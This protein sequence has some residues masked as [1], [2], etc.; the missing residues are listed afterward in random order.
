MHTPL[1]AEE[2][3]AERS[4]SELSVYS[5]LNRGARSIFVCRYCETD[6]S[7]G[8]LIPVDTKGRNMRGAD[9]SEYKEMYSEVNLANGSSLLGASLAEDDLNSVFS[10]KNPQ[11]LVYSKA[12]RR[13]HVSVLPENLPCRTLEKEKI[14]SYLRDGILRGGHVRPLYISGMPG[15]GKTACFM[16]AL[17]S[18]EEEN[19]KNKPRRDLVAAAG[20]EPSGKRPIR[21]IVESSSSADKLLPEFHFV[22]INCLK[23]HSPHDAYTVLWKGISGER[24]SAKTALQRLSDYFSISNNK[25]LVNG[26]SI[27]TVC[28]LDE[29]DFLVSGSESVVYN[30]FDWPQLQNSSLIVVG[31]ANT[32][33]L[34]ERL[35]NRVRS[36]MGGDQ[37]NRMIFQPYTHEQV[38]EILTARLIDL[39]VLG[40]K[41][42]QLLSRKAVN[43]AGDLRA[44]LKIC[45]R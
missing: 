12:I 17:R 16:A 13:L 11:L 41:E 39:Q 28:L 26:A 23:L 20:S 36:R 43:A 30:L 37:T 6:S 45:Q 24:V 34:P 10:G 7:S 4:G 9:L 19:D 8:L 1:E 27:V 2:N 42:L 22:E 21:P 29:L 35:S 5:T 31:I 33:D 44:A 14:M 18:L 3:M 32:M 40:D 38:R 15:S 25:K